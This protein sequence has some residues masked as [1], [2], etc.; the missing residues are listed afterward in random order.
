M[1][2]LQCVST[3]TSLPA[4]EVEKGKCLVGKG[5]WWL[6][7]QDPI[8]T[9]CPFQEEIPRRKASPA[10]TSLL[11]GRS[12][13]ER[14][15]AIWELSALFWRT[16]WKLQT[17]CLRKAAGTEPTLGLRFAGTESSQMRPR[18]FPCTCSQFVTASVMC[19]TLF[20]NTGKQ[21]DVL[22]GDKGC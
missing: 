18:T 19:L 13:S 15:E 20:S 1:F 22:P 16:S 12:S 10:L 21:T 2:T 6:E 5:P 7:S 8:L 14:E 3:V 11:E 9:R 17:G 4:G